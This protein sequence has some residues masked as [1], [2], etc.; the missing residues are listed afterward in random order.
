MHLA[1]VRP[2]FQ[3]TP[4]RGEYAVLDRADIQVNNV[5]FPVSLR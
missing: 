1:D 5:L 2:E 4:R 3:I